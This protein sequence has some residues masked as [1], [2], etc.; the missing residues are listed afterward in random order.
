[1]VWN[2]SRLSRRPEH[3]LTVYRRLAEAGVEVDFAHRPS[4]A[5]E[6]SWSGRATTVALIRLAIGQEPRARYAERTR[7]G[8]AAARA[9]R[10][11]QQ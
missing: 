9:R 8:I 5:P 7:R 10:A 1:V 2:G 3:F 4:G 6:H 11:G